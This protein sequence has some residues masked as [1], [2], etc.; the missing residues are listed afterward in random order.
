MNKRI[1]VIAGVLL[2][3]VLVA[4]W[5]YLLVFGVP[6][7]PSDVFA[8]F[9][10]APENDPSIVAPEVV[11]TDPQPTVAVGGASRLKQLTTR[12]VAG[13]A[14]LTSTTSAVMYAELGTGHLYHI[15]LTT[16]EERKV[17]GT[18]IPQAHDAH[19]AAD[20][21]L[22]V[23]RSRYHASSEVILGRVN[24]ST[25]EV[26][27]VV[28]DDAIGEHLLDLALTAENDLLYTVSGG[29]Q[30]TGH[31]LS[32]SSMSTRQLFT[33]PFSEATV[34]WGKSAGASHL[35]L[36]K[37]ARLL[38]G[39]LYQLR[40]GLSPLP[41]E[42]YGLTAAANAAYVLYNASVDGEYRSHSYNRASGESTRSALM[43]LPEKCAGDETDSTT[44]YCGYDIGS[45]NHELP[46]DWYQGAVRF[47]DDL[48][49]LDLE[50]GEAVSLVDIRGEAGREVDVVNIVHEPL[51]SNALFFINKN[52]NTLWMYDL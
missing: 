26:S 49:A 12:E 20:G 16:G 44:L 19:I 4:T 27:I 29:G 30:L 2:I 3:V 45:T 32:L 47:D 14:P 38:A 36:P 22:V 35:A 24:A 48:W 28:L 46:D 5:V 31:A 13:F 17:T 42:G 33:I 52:D 18:T 21:S 7:S 50:T 9:G 11:A 34:L 39:Y 1:L 51:Q 43:A 41:M 37:P 25:S 40:G 10:F 15:N 8:D 6:E 23:L